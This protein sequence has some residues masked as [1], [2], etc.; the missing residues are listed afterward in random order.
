MPSAQRRAHQGARGAAVER[1]AMTFFKRGHYLAHGLGRSIREAGHDLVDAHSQRELAQ[2]LWQVV[3]Q[4]GCFGSLLARVKALAL[5]Q[6]GSL[7]QRFQE[8]PQRLGDS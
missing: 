1:I 8:R 2:W 4:D 5:E 6:T 7:L 3:L